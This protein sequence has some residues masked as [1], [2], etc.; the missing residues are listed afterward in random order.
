MKFALTCALFALSACA[1]PQRGQ[2]YAISAELQPYVDFFEYTYGK[3][4][5]YSVL[6]GDGNGDQAYYDSRGYI[7]VDK[8]VFLMYNDA[9]RLE[10]LLHE[11][12]HGSFGRS[13]LDGRFISGEMIGCAKSLMTPSESV[14]LSGCFE[15]FMDY[16]LAELPRGF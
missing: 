12:G 1:G 2:N 14:T 13:H 5:D 11:F 16:Y 4:I 6:L 7:M 3:K 15:K 8:K 9:Q 10:L